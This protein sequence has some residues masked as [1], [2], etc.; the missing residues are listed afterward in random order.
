M[1]HLKVYHY[2]NCLQHCIDIYQ[3]RSLKRLC[4]HRTMKQLKNKQFNILSAGI[5]VIFFFTACSSSKQVTAQATPEEITQ[6][7]NNDRWNFTATFANP[8]YGT[9]RDITGGY[10]VICKKDTLNVSLPYYGKLNSP[11][12][13]MTGNPL[14][15]ESKEFKLTK[16]ERKP[17]E[18]LVTIKPVSSEV[19]SMNFTFFSNGSA[20]LNITMTNRTGISY[21][22][23]VAPVRTSN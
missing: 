7:I 14:D 19:Q 1:H 6:A 10:D 17:G 2:N 20:Q 12:G 13:A 23:K 9:A 22:G 3:V 18:W 16:E 11:A 21:Q 8:S 15:F 4:K 5:L